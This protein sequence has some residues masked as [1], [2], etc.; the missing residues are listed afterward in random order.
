MNGHRLSF[1]RLFMSHQGCLCCR[2]HSPPV[3]EFRGLYL[4]G[5]RVSFPW[6]FMSQQG[7]WGLTNP[8]VSCEKSF[9]GS[10]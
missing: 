8:F 7:L 10:F 6:L 9:E 5:Q 1:P 4:K 2:I 3:K